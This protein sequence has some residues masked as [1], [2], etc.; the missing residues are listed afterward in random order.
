MMRE[1]DVSLPAYLELGLHFGC[2]QH[3]AGRQSREQGNSQGA[4]NGKPAQQQITL[5]AK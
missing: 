4:T 3:S 2:G 1:V 5:T